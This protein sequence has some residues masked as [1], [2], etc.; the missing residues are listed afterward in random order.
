MPLNDQSERKNETGNPSLIYLQKPG[1]IVRNS[2]GPRGHD[3]NDNRT[4]VVVQRE[5]KQGSRREKPPGAAQGGEFH[6]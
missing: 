1:V 5:P 6:G 3:P 2:D 4:S